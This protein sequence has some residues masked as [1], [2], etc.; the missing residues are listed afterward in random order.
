MASVWDFNSQTLGTHTQAYNPCVKLAYVL[1]RGQAEL[2]NDDRDVYDDP[3]A[4]DVVG[5]D[6]CDNI[7]WYCKMRK[8]V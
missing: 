2:L 8:I 6:I 4:D 3:E 7:C 1:S 5:D